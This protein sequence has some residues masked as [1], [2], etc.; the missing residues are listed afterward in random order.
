MI[1]RSLAASLKTATRRQQYPR[2]QWRTDRIFESRSRWRM[3]ETAEAARESNKERLQSSLSSAAA[4]A[5]ADAAADTSRWSSLSP[6]TSRRHSQNRGERGRSGGARGGG[7]GRGGGGARGRG[8]GR[9][10]AR[11]YSN[12]NKTRKSKGPKIY[13]NDFAAFLQSLD[14]FRYKVH[15]PNC[16]CP[17]IKALRELAV[18]MGDDDNR[19]H[20]KNDNPLSNALVVIADSQAKFIPSVF[21][22]PVPQSSPSSSQNDAAAGNAAVEAMLDHEQSLKNVIF[23]GD[24]GVGESSTS[25]ATTIT[26]TENPFK[27]SCAA[28]LLTNV[29]N[30]FV[31]IN[32]A[33]RETVSRYARDVARDNAQQL[34]EQSISLHADHADHV[35]VLDSNDLLVKS[36]NRQN[37]DGRNKGR[38]GP[39]PRKSVDSPS[40]RNA[41]ESEGVD[42][43][44]VETV[45]LGH[46]VQSL[47]KIMKKKQYY[48]LAIV[49]RIE[50]GTTIEIDLPGG[51]RHL[52]ESSFDCA[53][54][55]TK[56]ETSLVVDA[57]WHAAANGKPMANASSDDFCNAF[58]DLTPPTASSN[59][60]DRQVDRISK[61]LEQV[62]L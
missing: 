22:H 15:K 8:R 34:I 24:D 62:K 14:N 51:K 55:E 52:G 45:K 48:F 47:L 40:L 10:A 60:S 20:N 3:T 58:Y 35:V 43:T 38:R 56:E 9:Q 25:T 17:K 27:I 59:H 44:N 13:R 2:R 41:L 57:T 61:S 53:I 16:Q 11:H 7:R 12:S 50:N 5:A 18:P 21:V 26:T 54:R 42:M 46:H 32:A 29:P 6:S 1:R 49:F 39:S 23:P 31:C 4:Q 28:C 37:R 36:S 30:G 19:D 33:S